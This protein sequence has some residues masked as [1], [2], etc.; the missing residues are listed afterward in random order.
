MVFSGRH[1]ALR[2]NDLYELD[3][4]TCKWRVIKFG[5]DIP[6]P[7]GRSWATLTYN[8]DADYFM[9]YG[10]IDSND[11]PLNESEFLFYLY[12]FD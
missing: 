10:G 11:Y 6:A 3:V 7:V 2:L 8:N 1:S 9:L 4:D 12:Y 5:D